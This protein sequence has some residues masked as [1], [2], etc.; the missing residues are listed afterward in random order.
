MYG[1]ET[2]EEED[3]WEIDLDFVTLE[4]EECEESHIDSEMTIGELMEWRYL[5]AEREKEQVSPSWFFLSYLY[6]L[7]LACLRSHVLR[8]E[9]SRSRKVNTR[10]Q[11]TDTSLPIKLSPK[12]HIISSTLLLHT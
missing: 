8:R 1:W 12:C 11:L 2:E 6:L 10:V 3:I 4:P 7:L 9:T 5:R